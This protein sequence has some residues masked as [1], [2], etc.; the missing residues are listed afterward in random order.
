MAMSSSAKMGLGVIIVLIVAVAA[1]L[2]LRGSTLSG[3]QT[4]SVPYTTTAAS[5]GGTPATPILLMDPPHLPAGATALIVSY[6]SIMAHTSGT[7]GSGWTNATGS[8]SI[9]MLSVLNSSKVIGYANISANSTINLIRLN[10]TSATI[11]INGTTYNVTIPNPQLTI[12]VAGKTK[13]SPTT[14]VLLSLSPTV[15]A[16]S[17]NN[18]TTYIMAPS[19]RAM[20]ITN[21]SGT[22]HAGVGADVSLSAQDRSE[23]EGG[24]L[25]I[26]LTGAALSVANNV[27][28]LSVTVTDNS[29]T[30]VTLHNLLLRGNETVT[31]SPSANVNASVKG[32]INGGLGGDS[33]NGII[34]DHANASAAEHTGLNIE[35]LRAVAFVIS[36]NGTLS[37][38]SGETDFEGS[39]VTV[40]PGASMT[41]SFNG[42]IMNNGGF[43]QV[44][45]KVG[46]TYSIDVIGE[47]NA[48]ASVTVSAT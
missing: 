19:A 22:A 25:N 20:V 41:L 43:F 1:L 27:T 24:E 39:G 6:S 38:P 18:S 8:G 31:V 42:I 12:A 10:V 11:T 3:P 35:A 9:N 48:A 7:A 21:V 28:T 33:V 44:A 29:N 40:A 37:V 16:F 47:E 17:N 15:S 5:S 13:I 45:P 14:G 36:S 46:A 34:E 32:D 23:F 4:T 2:V 26:T 30:T